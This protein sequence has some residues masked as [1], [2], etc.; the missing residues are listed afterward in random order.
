MKKK[1]G[2]RLSQISWPVNMKQLHKYGR[3]IRKNSALFYHH[4]RRSL[5]GYII[6]VIC[7]F[8]MNI[9]SL[10]QKWVPNFRIS[11][12]SYHFIAASYTLWLPGLLEKERRGFFQEGPV[13]ENTYYGC[14]WFFC[15][16]AAS[17]LNSIFIYLNTHMN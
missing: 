12:Y 3:N 4:F 16:A 6:F 17:H 14:Q 5:L 15:R 13:F 2:K 7:Y 8:Q 11:Y 1:I 10:S 9:K